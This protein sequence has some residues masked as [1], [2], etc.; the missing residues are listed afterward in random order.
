M[1][2]ITVKRTYGKKGT[3]GVLHADTLV[4]STIELPWLSNA[5]NISCIPEG[6][7]PYEVKYSNRW[8][9][10]VIWINDVPQRTAIQM[11][12]GNEIR[13]TMGCLLVGMTG[14]AGSDSIAP[15]VQRSKEALEALLKVIPKKGE[16]EIYS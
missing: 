11:H 10:D 1:S 14:K 16:I 5:R 6:T 12:V 8:K 2:D 13:H 3:S 9:R 7:Y 4:L 15:E